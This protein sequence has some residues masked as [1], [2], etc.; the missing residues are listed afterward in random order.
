MVSQF[1][2]CFKGLMFTLGLGIRM[3]IRFEPGIVAEF[4][5]G[6]MMFGKSKPCH[7]VVE[8]VL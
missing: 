2:C 7:A 8:V 4:E 1:H 5:D 6:S 3:R